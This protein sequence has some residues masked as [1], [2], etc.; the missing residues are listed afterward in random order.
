MKMRMHEVSGVGCWHVL[1]FCQYLVPPVMVWCSGDSKS[2]RGSTYL[3]FEINMK[4]CAFTTVVECGVHR[5][6]RYVIGTE[7]SRDMAYPSFLLEEHLTEASCREDIFTAFLQTMYNTPTTDAHR[8]NLDIYESFAIKL[9]SPSANESAGFANGIGATAVVSNI[10]WYVV[11]LRTFSNSFLHSYKL[12]FP[13][14]VNLSHT[15]NRHQYLAFVAHILPLIIINLVCTAVYPLAMPAEPCF[16][17]AAETAWQ[18][19][20]YCT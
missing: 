7:S 16:C 15:G 10:M 4:R 1:S 8:N 11:L 18:A 5:R 3:A 2:S 19:A 17:E 20:K 12:H 9:R 6:V 13:W 14:V